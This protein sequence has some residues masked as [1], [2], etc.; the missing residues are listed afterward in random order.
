MGIFAMGVSGRVGYQCSN[1]YRKLVEKGDIKD[2]NYV[3][4][5]DG[6]AD[7]CTRRESVN[8]N[9]HVILIRSIR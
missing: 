6:K 4:G 5:E 2:P 9:D 7:I 1:F 3:I 8:R